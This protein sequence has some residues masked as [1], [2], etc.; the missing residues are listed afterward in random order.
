MTELLRISNNQGDVSTHVVFL[1][2]LSGHIKRT[3]TNTV[4]PSPILWPT[5]LAEDI[6]SIELWLVGFDPV[7]EG[8]G[9]IVLN[10]DGSTQRTP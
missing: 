7:P 3:W 6:D 2:G 5:W 10:T 8:K 9:F 4:S 1:H